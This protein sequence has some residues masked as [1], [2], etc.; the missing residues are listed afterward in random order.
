MSKYQEEIDRIFGTKNAEWLLN[1]W[2]KQYG[3]RLSYMAGM[4]PEEVAFR[5]GERSFY[6]HIKEVLNERRSRD[7]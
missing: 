6:L 3:D 7:N 5:E 2:Q 1:E 4:E